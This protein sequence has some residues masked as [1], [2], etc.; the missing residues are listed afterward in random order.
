M[1]KFIN[2]KVFLYYLVDKEM[3]HSHLFEKYLGMVYLCKP[4]LNNSQYKLHY[5]PERSNNLTITND[6]KDITMINNRQGIGHIVN[7]CN[8]LRDY[9]RRINFTKW[10]IYSPIFFSHLKINKL[11]RKY[12]STNLFEGKLDPHWVTGFIDAEGCFSVIIEV[13][14][15]LKSKVRI[16]FE[17][18]LHEKDKEILYK[19]QKF[20]GVGNIYHRPDRRKSVYNKE[21]NNIVFIK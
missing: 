21:K 20:F 14:E 5:M 1:S 19:I 11:L 8:I 10:L 3:V 4:K 9:T 13:S 12:Y 17:I 16:S 6:F 18:N 7:M 2:N 15:S